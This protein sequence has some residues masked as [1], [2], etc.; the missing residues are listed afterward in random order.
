MDVIYSWKF[1]LQSKKFA[2]E[3]PKLWN[4]SSK[5]FMAHAQVYENEIASWNGNFL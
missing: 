4:F 5:S 2:R 3:Q 1:G